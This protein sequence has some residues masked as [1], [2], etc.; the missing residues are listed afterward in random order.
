MPE[1]LTHEQH[2]DHIT[3]RL[4]DM[5][6]AYAAWKAKRTTILVAARHMRCSMELRWAI[7][8]GRRAGLTDL[9]LGVALRMEPAAAAIWTDVLVEHAQ[10]AHQIGAPS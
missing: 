6:D 3:R 4:D 9:D 2:I 7:V 5:L 8:E 10:P 1:P